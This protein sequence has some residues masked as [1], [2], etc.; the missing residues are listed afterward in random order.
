MKDLDK[1]NLYDFRIEFDLLSIPHFGNQI[2]KRVI[3]SEPEVKKNLRLN[4]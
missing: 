4:N 3:Q 2:L 1:K